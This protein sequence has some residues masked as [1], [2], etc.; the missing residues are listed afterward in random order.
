M[1]LKTKFLIWLRYF[2]EQENK[3]ILQSEYARKHS[4]MLEDFIVNLVIKATQ[5]YMLTPV[6][7]K[8]NIFIPRHNCFVPTI[9]N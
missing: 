2:E 8:V 4:N 1:N 9:N 3:Q 5:F 7:V 6:N